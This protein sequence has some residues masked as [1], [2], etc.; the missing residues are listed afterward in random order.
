MAVPTYDEIMFPLLKFCQDGNEHSR[1]ELVETLSDHFKLTEEEKQK[2]LP[3]GSM[4]Y[5]YNRLGWAKLGLVKAG[6]LNSPKRGVYKIT[7]EGAKLINS[8]ISEVDSKH[9]FD[10]Y[11]SFREWKG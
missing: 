7:S 3:S 11:A 10:N 8:G 5:I 6:L 1:K 9:L 4:T 2:R